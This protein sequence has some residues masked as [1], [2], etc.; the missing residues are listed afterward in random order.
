MI[1][2][3]SDFSL[4]RKPAKPMR[5]KGKKLALRYKILLSAVSICLFLFVIEVATRLFFRFPLD[6]DYGIYPEVLGDHLPRQSLVAVHTSYDKDTPFSV[7]INAEGLR[8]KEVPRVKKPGQE[9]ILCMG[10]SFAYGLFLDEGDTFPVQLQ[11]ELRR[12]TGSDRYE[13][14]NAGHLDYTITEELEYLKERGL[15]L[16]PD[17]VVLQFTAVNDIEDLTRPESIRNYYRNLASPNVWI[18][19]TRRFF[20]KWRFYQAMVYAWTRVRARYWYRRIYPDADDWFRSGR[21]YFDA[22]DRNWKIS[23]DVLKVGKE[24]FSSRE[25]Q[26]KLESLWEKYSLILDSFKRELDRRRIKLIILFYPD[27]RELGRSPR[28][29]RSAGYGFS[30]R[31]SMGSLVAALNCSSYIDLT[32]PFTDVREERGSVLYDKLH[33]TFEASRIAAGRVA[34]VLLAKA[35]TR[36]IESEDKGRGMASGVR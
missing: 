26:E 6:I 3:K 18:C 1:S 29:L 8:G 33:P 22:V 34:G 2:S 32:G 20:H 19:A 31:E 11:R 13:V 30:A 16:Q 17:W 28:P 14:I 9:R 15:K 7:R 5:K 23:D 12:R 10:D 4:K 24:D 21:M 35:S 27:P 36:S 25:F